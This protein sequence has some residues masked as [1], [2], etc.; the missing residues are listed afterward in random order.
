MADKRM[1]WIR[2]V[3]AWERSG[4]TRVAFCAARGLK[5][6]TFDYWRRVLRRSPARELVPIVVAPEQASPAMPVEVVL[7]NG[8]R[9]QVTPGSDL[10]SLRAL[11]QAL[12]AC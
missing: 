10:S 8:I 2:R 6:P 3:E 1:A 12:R 7:P 11:V 4:Q 5:L 9:L